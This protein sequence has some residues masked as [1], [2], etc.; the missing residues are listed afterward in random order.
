VKHATCTSRILD[1]S[2]GSE[3]ARIIGKGNKERLAMLY[4]APHTMAMLPAYLSATGI[5][6]GPLFPGDKGPIC[7][8]TLHHAWVKYCTIAGVNAH[9]H[10][11]RHGFATGLINDGVDIMVVRDL[12]GHDSVATTQLYAAVAGRYIKDLLV[13]AGRVEISSKTS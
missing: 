3:T 9:A 12:L 8:R 1:L 5:Q 6:A 2:P 13:R 10:D 7:Y 11:L 4:A